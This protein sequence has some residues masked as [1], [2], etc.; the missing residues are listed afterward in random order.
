MNAVN[1]ATGFKTLAT[2]AGVVIAAGIMV[3]VMCALPGAGLAQDISEQAPG[4]GETA[5]S[6]GTEKLSMPQLEQLLAP[7]ALYPDTL[8]SQILMA[9]TYPL[10]VVEAYRWVSE[11][12]NAA[13]NGQALESALQ[14]RDWDP[15]VK[16]LVPFPDI[17]KTMN[18]KLGWM[19]Q[20]GNAF[21]VQ[22]GDIMDAVQHLRAQ[23]AAAGNLQSNDQ[24]KVTSTQQTIIIEPASTQLVYVPYYDPLVVYGL[25]PWSAYPPVYFEPFPGYAIHTGIFTWFSFGTISLFW[26]WSSWDWQQHNIHIDRQR[27]NRLLFFNRRTAYLRD[28]WVHNPYHRRG[29]A[30]PDPQLRARFRPYPKGTATSRINYRGFLPAPRQ[31]I[32]MPQ[33]GTSRRRAAVPPRRQAT[34]PQQAREYTRRVQPSMRTAP[35]P[36]PAAARTPV[37]RTA[38]ARG[39]SPGKPPPAFENYTSGAAA[40]AAVERARTSRRT[41]VA[42]PRVPRQNTPPV[43][44]T[45]NKRKRPN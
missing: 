13:L 11:T 41:P 19:Q 33:I 37:T 10:E 3:A 23:A 42:R 22:E 15:S 1:Q 44:R 14:V 29:V 8:L 39:I 12:N 35:V 9:S 32:T 45:V 34:Q 31:P 16:S 20:L 4:R 6:N 25:W 38:P 30:Y 21:L 18:D 28:T 5:Q 43:N 36:P 24:Q 17:L 7:I 40:R 27:Y 2:R 26:G